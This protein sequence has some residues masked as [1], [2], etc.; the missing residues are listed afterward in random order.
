MHGCGVLGAALKRAVAWPAGGVDI[1]RPGASGGSGS[2]RVWCARL[3][4]GRGREP[5]SGG[6]SRREGLLGVGA[7]V[8][9]EG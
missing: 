3:P 1:H 7:V 4:T 8:G 2:G 6:G 9:G 5:G